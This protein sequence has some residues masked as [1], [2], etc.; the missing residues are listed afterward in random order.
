MYLCKLFSLFV[1]VHV[2]VCKSE[3]MD[4]WTLLPNLSSLG[5]CGIHKGRDIGEGRS[6]PAAQVALV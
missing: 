6:L 5:L 1:F 4:T 3:R 2:S